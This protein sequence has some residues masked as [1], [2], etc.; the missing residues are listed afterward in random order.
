M[1]RVVRVNG[2]NKMNLSEE[3]D[4]KK[5]EGGMHFKTIVPESGNIL[6]LNGNDKMV[7]C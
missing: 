3:N 4:N 7:V 2:Q 1:I 5:A 6:G